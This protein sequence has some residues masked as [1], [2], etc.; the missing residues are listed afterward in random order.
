VARAVEYTELPADA[1]GSRT[2]G[3]KAGGCGLRRGGFGE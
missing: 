2:S 3:I 1:A